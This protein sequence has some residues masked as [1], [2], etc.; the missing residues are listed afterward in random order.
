[1]RAAPLIAATALLLATPANAGLSRAALDAATASPHP[2]AAIPLSLAFTDET[3]ARRTFGDA[4]GGGP[5][6]L[7]F[8]DVTCR[9]L[10]GP[11]VEFVASGLA[12]SGLSPGKDYRLVII[13]LDP[14]DSVAQARDFKAR[15]ID[16]R[17]PLAAAT[18]VLS[19]NQATVEAA[20]AA[21]GYRYA[22]DAEH[23][24][25]AH[26]AAAFTIDP[27]GRIARVLSPLA[28]DG[29]DL[30]LGLIE[31]ANGRIGT[32]A[33]QVRLLCYGFDPVTGIY[34]LSIMR[35][36][37]IGAMVTIAAL[38]TGIGLMLHRGGG[39]AP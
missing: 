17:S 5:A 21:A 30:R 37:A 35:W 8:A 14:R 28:L 39:T 16:A 33:D 31:A 36:L 19:G 29:A 22:Y 24:Q 32:F 7:L 20:T 9:T 26:P 25:F 27:M 13:G 15:H 10:C 2:D 18:T 12:R 4:L 23:D 11:I 1:M 38:S 6:V 3:G 34:T